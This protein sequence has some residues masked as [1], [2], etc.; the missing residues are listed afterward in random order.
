MGNCGFNHFIPNSIIGQSEGVFVTALELGYSS[1]DIDIMY[2]AFQNLDIDRKGTVSIE[3]FITAYKI[4]NERFM[5]LT[6]S[7]FDEDKSGGTFICHL[8]DDYFF[9]PENIRFFVIDE[10]LF[11]YVHAQLCT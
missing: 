1:S 6:L 5:V 4:T 2:T 9:H 7:I 3:E 8:F 10:H 11:T